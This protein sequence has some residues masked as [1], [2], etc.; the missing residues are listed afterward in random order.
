MLALPHLEEQAQLVA[1]IV[2]QVVAGVQVLI[3]VLQAANREGEWPPTSR[4][5]GGL[6]APDI[7]GWLSSLCCSQD[8][9]GSACECECRPGNSPLDIST[10]AG[11][12]ALVKGSYT[13]AQD[14]KATASSHC[15]AA[16]SAA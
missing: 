16:N 1:P 12:D 2:L 5:W 8:G 4:A 6:N 10:H 14:L 7:K 15:Q 9:T 11:P 3:Q 13:I